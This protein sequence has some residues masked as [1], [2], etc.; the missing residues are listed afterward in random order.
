MQH[1]LFHSTPDHRPAYTV[2]IPPPNVTGVLHMGHMLNNSIQDILVRRARQRGFNA[3]WVPGTDHASIATEAKVVGRLA[4]QGIQKHDLT[5]EAF[6]EHAW[7]WTREHGG[8]ILEQL[9]RLG[10][11]CDWERTAFTMDD[12]RSQSVIDVF[13][14]L[15]RKGLIYRGVRVVNWDPKAQTA[16]SDEEVIYQEQQG[17]LYYLRYFVEGEADKYVVVATTRP[18][19]I[20]GDTAVCINPNDERYHFLRGKKLI[21]PIVGRAVPVIEDEYVDIEFGTGCLKV[22]PAHDVNDYMLGEKHQL[23]TI[24]IFHDDGTLNE[25]GGAYAGMDRFDVRKKIEADLIAAGL[26]EKV[27][28]YTNKVGHSERTFVPIEPKL[29]MQWFLKMDGLAKPALD[30]V[31]NDEIRLHP[32]KFKNTYRHWME[33]IK[34]WCISRQLWWGHRIPAYYLPD[35]SFVVAASDEEALRLAQE[36]NA[37]LTAADLR[38]ESDCLDTWFSSWLWPITVFAPALS[39]GNEELDYYYPTSDLVT[40][41]DILFFW[42]ARM[43]MAGYEFQGKKP[44]ENVYLTGI[45]RDNQG[46]KM[47]K[48][49]GN[50]PDPLLLIDKYGADGVR[51]GLIMS[52]PAGNDILFD[53]SLCEQGR[54]FCNKIWNAFRLVK[55]WT[56]EAAATPQPEA[57]RLASYWMRQVLNKAATELDDLFAKYRISEALTL[58]YKLIRDDFS[59]AYLELIKPAYGSPIDETTCR[60]ALDFFDEILRILHPFMPFITEELWQNLAERADGES[61]MNAQQRPA[62]AYD[63]AFLARFAAAQEII[64]TVR[65]LRTS[66]NLSPR[67]ALGLEASPSYPAE[68]DEVLIKMAGLS[69]IDRSGVRSEGAVTFVIGTD[70]FAVPMAAYIDVEEE[71]K[72]L[73]A[74]LEY[75]QKFLAGVEKKLSNE[76]FVS[77]APEAVISLERKKKADAESRIATIEQ[78]IR[79]LSGN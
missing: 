20:M 14:D 67:E 36:K 28:D 3:C 22:T 26:M 30:A 34:D 33:N 64:T 52:A 42:V 71:L 46:R 35:G 57:S 73:R 65:S 55:G 5:R 58:V 1:K 38:R 9:K 24:D 12:E 19:T 17:K 68:L 4:A 78:S 59:S 32:A 69:A 18:E 25:H 72:K 15:Y 63:E 51:M 56:G 49:L 8:I 31:M 16:L 21:V 23:Q 60:E 76:S 70:E 44:F 53:E 13:V 7:D 2:V 6:L 40:G 10:A 29:S 54:N 37:D 27:E 45:V 39:K 75:Q 62:E 43:I 66:K 61:I 79:Q 41:P 50:S 47:S 77:K 74:D 11:S 48:T